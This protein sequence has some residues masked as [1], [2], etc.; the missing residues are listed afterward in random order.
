MDAEA[1]TAPG[2]YLLVLQLE[3]ALHDLAVGRFG[4]FA[5]AAGYYLYV[6]SA[7]GSGGLAARL[8]HH[9]RRDK[10]RLHWHIDYLRPHARVVETW[11]VAS[12]TRLECDWCGSLRVAPELTLPIRHFGSRDRGC[13]GHLFYAPRRPSLSLLTQSLLVVLPASSSGVVLEI[14]RHDDE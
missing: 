9:L 10:P 6:G 14:T 8:R 7:L 13:P 3:Q 5:F 11:A 12:P 2:T 4:R 1:L